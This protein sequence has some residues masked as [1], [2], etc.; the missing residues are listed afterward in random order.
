[1]PTAAPVPPLPGVSPGRA[2]VGVLRQ[3]RQTFAALVLRPTWWLP[4]VVGVLL[5]AVFSVVMTDKIDYDAAMRQAVEKRA[6]RSG[7]TMSRQQMDDSID[8]AVEVQRKIAPFS[9]TIG[10]AMYAFV[11]FVIAL[12]LAFAGNAFGA[13]AKIPVF[14]ALYAYAQIPLLLRSAVSLVRLFFAADTS[15]TFDDLGRLGAIGPAAFLSPRTSPPLVWAAASSC[16][17]LIMATV[18]LLV[19]AF[20]A[21]PGLSRKSATILPI[22]LWGGM[23]LLRLGWAALF[24]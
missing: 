20:R 15:L 2:V 17:L 5:S 22:A 4:F 23:V 12:V 8:R 3:P 21:V 1:M 19:L 18:F 11:F 14:L 7:Q 6:A 24:G 10:A 16:D 9:P 13:E